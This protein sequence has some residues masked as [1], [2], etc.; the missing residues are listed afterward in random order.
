MLALHGSVTLGGAQVSSINTL[1]LFCTESNFV[2]SST[3]DVSRS[4]SPMPRVEAHVVQRLASQE[5]TK[6]QIPTS[7]FP[8]SIMVLYR[9][10]TKLQVDQ[11]PLVDL[12]DLL[13]SQ[14]LVRWLQLLRQY[15]QRLR[16]SQ[17]LWERLLLYNLLPQVQAREVLARHSMVSV[18][19]LD[20]LVPLHV[21]REDAL[22][23]ANITRNV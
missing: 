5:T 15:P 18:E 9:L 14:Q 19:V 21:L 8:T 7:S 22:Q 11:S 4:R 12:V 6:P 17:Q 23:M 10:P 13:L 2:Y 16:L 3:S 20:G 1:L